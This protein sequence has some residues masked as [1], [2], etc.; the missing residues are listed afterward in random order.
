M[1][2]GISGVT[3]LAQRG[4]MIHRRN[5]KR[6]GYSSE[7]PWACVCVHPCKW[8]QA[9]FLSIDKVLHGKD[10]RLPCASSV[11][12]FIM[13][14]IGTTWQFLSQPS[15]S[16]GPSTLSSGWQTL[17]SRYNSLWYLQMIWDIAF[18]HFWDVI[19]TRV[20]CRTISAFDSIY[21][22]RGGMW[23]EA[24]RCCL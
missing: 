15:I 18:S 24:E 19:G 11:G 14:E 13:W 6:G 16:P 8:Q 23:G 4:L 1:L 17:S 20:C 2:T 21:F 5:D 22:K 9:C 12:C 10:L 7:V 3:I